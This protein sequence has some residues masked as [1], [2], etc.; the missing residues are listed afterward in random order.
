MI[1]WFARNHVAAN[2]L[3]ITIVFLG[4]YSISEEL[5]LE[6]FPKFDTGVVTVSVTLRGATPEEVEQS[7]AIRFRGRREGGQPFQ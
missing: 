6:F 2:L 5:P 3:L 1:S 4:L 7:V